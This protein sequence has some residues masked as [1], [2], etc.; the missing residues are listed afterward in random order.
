MLQ[1]TQVATV[2]P[3]YKRFIAVFPT[4]ESL[5]CAPLDDVLKLWENLG[6]YARARNLH[7]A[8]QVVV[9]NYN[10]KLPDSEDDLRAL[11]GV[12]PYLAGALASMA[13]NQPVPAV[14]A[15]VKRVM[16][17]IFNIDQPVEQA[18]T[19]KQIQEIAESLVPKKR[20]GD[21]NQ[22]LMDLGARICIPRN[23]KCE[24]C[25]LSKLCQARGRGLQ[26]TLPIKAKAKA[27]PHRQAVA[28]VIK[29]NKGRYLMVRR[30]NKGLLG[31]LWKWPG[32]LLEHKES[33][34]TGLKRTV[35]GELGINIRP[36]KHLADVGHEFSH[37][38][39]TLS[40][41]RA[42]MKKGDIQALD[43]SEW[44]WVS[45]D[46]FNDLALAKADRDAARKIMDT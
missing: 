29:D 38:R 13:F 1:Q 26:N 33:A 43:C 44:R 9:S 14:D 18:R 32:G 27:K 24:Q 7:R 37:F 4:V 25:P 28:A 17:C 21:Y 10:G 42:S 39:M 36:G 46:Q 30:K 6:Y 16:A 3:Y 2:I 40:V 45:T 19:Q 8:A 5:A 12:G 20:P 11:P 22:A 15:N 35:G 23:P 34:S 31:G 41:Y